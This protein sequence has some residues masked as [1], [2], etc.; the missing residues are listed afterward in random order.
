MLTE[1]PAKKEIKETLDESNLQAA[2]G[3]DGLT[4][5]L[6]KECWHILGDPLTEVVHEVF[7]GSQPTKSQRTSLMVFGCKPKKPLSS[8]PEDKRK[9]SLLNSDFKLCTGIESKRFKK[10]ATHTRGG[11]NIILSANRYFCFQ[12]FLPSCVIFDLICLVILH[13]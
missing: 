2:P 9:I 13:Q 10:V 8:K 11:K 7:K 3:T 12:I 5:F 1:L 6:Y 4:S